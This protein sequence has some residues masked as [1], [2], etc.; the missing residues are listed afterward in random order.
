[1]FYRWPIDG[2]PAS[3]SGGADRGTAGT[4]DVR[5]RAR[6]AMR[7]GSWRHYAVPSIYH[8]AFRRSL[9]DAI[10]DR[11]GRVFHTMTPDVF[12]A[13]A[14]A[15]LT[16]EALSVGFGVTV[17]GASAQS[18]SGR[19][20]QARTDAAAD[21]WGEHLAEYADHQIHA[22]LYPDV[23][24]RVNT[25][26]SALLVARDLFPE[27][28][29]A[30]AFG[31]SEMWAYLLRTRDV[32]AWNASPSWVLGQRQRIRRHHPFSVGRFTAASALH[33][34]VALTSRLR[35]RRRVISL[36]DSVPSD[37]AGFV[38]RLGGAV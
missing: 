38:T 35:R 31:Y 18:N 23:P 37:I 7:M 24:I 17:S 8:S 20:M 26:P 19:M 16:D 9:V 11:T 15:A 13:F 21:A 14:A 36:A 2:A 28:Y 5:R 22:S 30:D 33:T 34:G 29:A 32:C 4:I 25:I 1:M 12:A 10:R 6:F 3:A 27:A